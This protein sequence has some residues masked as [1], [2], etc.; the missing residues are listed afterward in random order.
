[1]NAFYDDLR[2]IFCF[3]KEMKVTKAVRHT[4]HSE[5]R[6]VVR[7][8]YLRTVCD[9]MLNLEVGP[10]GGSGLHVEI[11]ETHFFQNK[12]HL[13][14]PTE[15][16]RREYVFG[17]LCKE[18]KQVVMIRVQRC[19]KATLWPLMLQYVRADSI[20]NID[21]AK[22]YEDLCKPDGIAYKFIFAKRQIVI[23]KNGEY[24]EPT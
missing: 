9:R 16:Q 5:P 19:D 12:Y 8:K 15:M 20:I 3:T 14:R 24:K 21:G 4:G 23:H 1:M 7:Y 22:V 18:T 2:L 17:I 10:I 6:V 11:D 13:G